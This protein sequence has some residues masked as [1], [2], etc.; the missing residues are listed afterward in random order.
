MIKSLE[1]KDLSYPTFQSLLPAG[2]VA[3]GPYI[4]RFAHNQEDLEAIQRLRF[5]VFNLELGEGFDASYETGL[6]QDEFDP[7]C[8]HL[9]V[10]DWEM[11]DV[12]GTYRLQ[13]YE[14]ASQGIGFYSAIE[15]DL[16]AISDR[17]IQN[18]VEI[19]RACVSKKHRSLK[20]LYLLWSGIGLYLDHNHKQYL[21]GCCSLT[22][23]NPVEGKEVMNYLESG[24]FI[25]PEHKVVP[26]PGFLCYPDDLLEEGIGKNKVP[27]LMKIY[28]SV[29][30]KICGPPAIDRL[31]ETIDYLTFF[32]ME[33]LDQRA[34]RY[35]HYRS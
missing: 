1:T 31:F 17:N 13:T 14:M 30:A 34:L 12:V 35:F 22:S 23:Q 25:H 9:M 19:G 3:S 2:N 10:R 7:Y 4:V 6:D 8:H 11:G 15:F 5:E 33:T 28:L 20:V 29:G 21:F 16:S 32:D 26:N 27:R 18:A 24:N